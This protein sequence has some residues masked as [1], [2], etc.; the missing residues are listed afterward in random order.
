VIRRFREKHARVSRHGTP[1]MR[2]RD[3]PILLIHPQNSTIV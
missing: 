2:G 1:P 3:E